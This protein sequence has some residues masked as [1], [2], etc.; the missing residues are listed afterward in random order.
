MLLMIN[1]QK[2]P[3]SVEAPL[4]N[5]DFQKVDAQNFLKQMDFL[6]LCKETT[7]NITSPFWKTAVPTQH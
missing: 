2:Y 3:A 4:G 5:T 1:T 6:W 7:P